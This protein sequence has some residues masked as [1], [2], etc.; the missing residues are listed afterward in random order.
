MDYLVSVIIPVYN[1]EKYI[2]RAVE[3]VIKQNNSQRYQIILV[4]D[5]SKDS[6][7]KI[8][9]ELSE[10][11]DNV[12]V[13]HQKN[14][15]V[16]AARNLGI[17][18]AEGEWISFIDADDYIL[19]GFYDSLLDGETA[20]LLC[21]DLHVEKVNFPLIGKSIKDGIYLK[22]DF[23]EVLYPLM[24]EPN[25]FYS[26]CNKVFR[27]DIIKKTGLQF[28]VGMKL[29]ED[30]TFVYEYVRH[31]ESFKFVNKQL[32][33]YYMIEGS[34]SSVVSKSYETFKSTFLYHSAY[35]HSYGADVKIQKKLKNIYLEN[36]VNSILVA[37][38]NLHLFDGVKYISSILNDDLF[39]TN[40]IE[41]PVCKNRYGIYGYMD[42]WIARKN[43]F[44]VYMMIKLNQLRIKIKTGK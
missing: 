33:F 23:N 4:N 8:C 37:A 42:K 7:G 19:D 15:G 40:Y 34:A 14:A 32:Y 3:S 24:T 9:D 18:K 29:A 27:N 39:Y 30:M 35:F 26:A 22:S 21:C 16:S 20:D 1:C 5:G 36:S 28:V 11:Y 12:F 41:N 25:V 10:K 17:E 13:F 2:E 31:I 6:S 38:I 44:V 43:A